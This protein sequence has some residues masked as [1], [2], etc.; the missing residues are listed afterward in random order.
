[1]IGRLARGLAAGATGTIALELTTYLDILIRGR[2]PSDQPQRLGAALAGRLGVAAGD[3]EAARSRRSGLGSAT[4]YIDGLTLPMLYA[5]VAP[6]RDRPVRTV[7]LLLSAGAM[8]GSNGPAVALGLTDPRD[9]SLDDWVTDVVPHLI[10]GFVAA[11][12]YELLITRPA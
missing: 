9:W 6:R 1:M 10:Y 12:M 3:D 8:I 11:T 5:V 2:P 7:A 4:G